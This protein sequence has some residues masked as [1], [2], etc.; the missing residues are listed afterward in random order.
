MYMRA[1]VRAYV[2]SCVCVCVCVRACVCARARARVCVCVCVCWWMG[3]TY[4]LFKV[5]DK[6]TCSLNDLNKRSFI[7]HRDI[8][9]LPPPPRFNAAPMVL[10]PTRT[11]QTT[12]GNQATTVVGFQHLFPSLR[13]IRSET[14]TAWKTNLTR[15]APLPDQCLSLIHI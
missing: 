5:Q 12:T 7:H 13:L 2:R 10:T 9:T 8:T 15:H 1:C 11:A 14:R 3:Y 6:I 4:S